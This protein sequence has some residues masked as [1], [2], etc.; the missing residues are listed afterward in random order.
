M[1]LILIPFFRSIMSNGFCIIFDFDFQATFDCHIDLIY[2]YF[3]IIVVVA[4]SAR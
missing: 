3:P 2:I 4:P 1:M